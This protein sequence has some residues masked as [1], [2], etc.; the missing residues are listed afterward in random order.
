MMQEDPTHCDLCRK[1]IDGCW[2]QTLNARGEVIESRCMPCDAARRL[3]AY[4]ETGRLTTR[5]VESAQID[6]ALGKR[7]NLDVLADYETVAP[8]IKRFERD[9]WFGGLQA[10]ARNAKTKG[11]S[12]EANGLKLLCFTM[13]GRAMMTIDEPDASVTTITEEDSSE[14]RMGLRGIDAT[15]DR[16]VELLIKVRRLWK[17]GALKVKDDRGVTLA[18]PGMLAGQDSQ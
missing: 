9:V 2:S 6:Q 12:A 5:L 3:T 16:A 8:H 15:A 10:L 11:T 13:C 17:A 4:R 1:P 18:I 7:A 14:S